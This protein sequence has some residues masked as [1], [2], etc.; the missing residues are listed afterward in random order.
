MADENPQKIIIPPI[1]TFVVRRMNPVL[2]ETAS[3]ESLTVRAHMWR[4][5]EGTLIFS[6][7]SI[8][9]GHPFSADIHA[10]FANLLDVEEVVTPIEPQ[11]KI[12]H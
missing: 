2:G 6:L 9:Q 8:N 4:M 10:F 3:V 7:Y 5:D 11:S 1:R 12:V